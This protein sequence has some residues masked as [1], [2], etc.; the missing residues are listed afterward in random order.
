M[1]Q[2]KIY[3]N[4]PMSDADKKRLEREEHFWTAPRLVVLTFV[5]LSIALTVLYSMANFVDGGKSETY[6]N[7]WMKPAG[8][9]HELEYENTQNVP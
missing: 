1:P 5:T 4:V 7:D 2:P 9:Q 8:L 6:W 3:I